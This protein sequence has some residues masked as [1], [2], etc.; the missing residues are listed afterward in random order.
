MAGNTYGDISPAV[1]GFVIGRFLKAAMPVLTTEKFAV[2]NQLK[3]NNTRTTKWRRYYITGDSGA[4][5]PDSGNFAI[6]LPITPL[7]EGQTPAS[8]KLVSKDYTVQIQQ[9]GEVF[10]LTDVI[11]DTHTD[12]VLQVMADKAGERGGMLREQ[13]NLNTLRAGV[14]V[15]YAN[16][17]ARNQVTG[18]LTRALQRRATN[19][20][21]R[22]GGMPIT[23]VMSSSV[24]YGTRSV[25]PAYV[26]IGHVDLESDIR[27]M[28]GYKN[29]A[30]Y[31]RPGEAFE[32]EV[33]SVERVRYV[34]TLM[35]TPF[36]D[37]G[38]AAGGTLRSTGGTN[39]D[40][41]PVVVM[42]RDAWGTVSLA[43]TEAVR[44][45]VTNPKPSAA[46]PLAQRGYVGYKMYHAV[47][48]LMELWMV[49]ME[50]ACSL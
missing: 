41:Y 50:V 47:A 9:Y 38:G 32:G 22:Q 26:A 8:K 7:T 48:I 19:R 21:M 30:D 23:N 27:D 39:A 36:A 29:P 28:E 40:V 12:P 6:D 14:N 31:A 43:G 16:G 37:A 10:E 35:A 20:L 17:T 49:R 3:K 42:A 24:N 5:G 15:L 45:L 13:L 4:A 33:G 25:E 18:K 34:L 44:I 46:D 1:E 2:A 11:E